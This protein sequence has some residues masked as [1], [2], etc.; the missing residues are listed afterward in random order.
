MLKEARYYYEELLLDSN[1]FLTLGKNIAWFTW[2]GDNVQ[3]TLTLLL[4]KNG[5]KANNEGLYISIQNS[6]S[7][8]VKNMLMDLANGPLPSAEDLAALVKNK[9]QE[10]WDFLLP[11][12]L[13]CKNYASL[14][15]D[16]ANAREAL[17]KLAFKT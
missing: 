4:I 6:N 17:R 3:D 14:Y 7:E 15:L 9:Q 12:P 16:L 1:E 11:E 10:K 13:L 2:K 8:D 5:L